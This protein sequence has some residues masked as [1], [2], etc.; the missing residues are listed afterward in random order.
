MLKCLGVKIIINHYIS[1]YGKILK[2]YSTVVFFS[3]SVFL[4]CFLGI[5]GLL[6]NIPMADPDRAWESCG[7]TSVQRKCWGSGF[8]PWASEVSCFWGNS[9]AYFKNGLDFHFSQRLDN[10]DCLRYNGRSVLKRGL[11][12][13]KEKNKFN[14][15]DA[16]SKFWEFM[17]IILCILVI[18]YDCSW[19]L[20]QLQLFG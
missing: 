14:S 3:S 12:V 17:A 13:L 6:E 5:L 20:K 19:N 7:M 16:A 9:N 11:C 1:K 8:C 4:L 2:R 18:I 15:L 10:I